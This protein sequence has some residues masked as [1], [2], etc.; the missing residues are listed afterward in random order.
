MCV[1]VLTFL[2]SLQTSSQDGIGKL[3]SRLPSESSPTPPVLE[4]SHLLFFST[5]TEL[6]PVFLLVL[7]NAMDGILNS[8]VKNRIENLKCLYRAGS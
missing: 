4:T 8:W 1:A 3:H 6:L 7:L 2:K 5:E